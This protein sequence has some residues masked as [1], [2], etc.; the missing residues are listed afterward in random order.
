MKNRK[1]QAFSDLTACG[2]KSFGYIIA[3]NGRPVAET[4]ENGTIAYMVKPTIDLTF[5]IECLLAKMAFYEGM[6]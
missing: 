2:C 6:E 3:R 5:G 1:H 4:D